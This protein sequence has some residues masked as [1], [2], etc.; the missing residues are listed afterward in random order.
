MSSQDTLER[1]WLRT[2]EPGIEQIMRRLEDGI[3][4]GKYL[5]LY[6]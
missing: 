2:L 4:H 3:P 6:K 5:E 1:A